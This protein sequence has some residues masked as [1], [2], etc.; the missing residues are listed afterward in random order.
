MADL[1]GRDIKLDDQG[2]ALV[3]A[4]GELILTDGVETGVQDVRLRLGSPLGELFYDISFGS[5]CHEF[6]LDESSPG[7][8]AGFEAEVEQRIEEDPRVVLGSATCNV[9]STN[10][11]GFS[12]TAS[13]TFIGEDTVFNL[14]FTY[15]G[16]K[17]TMVINDVN[18][19]TGL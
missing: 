14:V 2:Q 7:K 11:L 19:R 6:Y 17:K 12:A 1:F 8:P 10:A 18:P 5:L 3:A 4:N 9:V 13:W 15:D 16:T